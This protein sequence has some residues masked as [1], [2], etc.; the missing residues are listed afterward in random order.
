MVPPRAGVRGSKRV[1]GYGKHNCP[2]EKTRT[3]GCFTIGEAI[4]APA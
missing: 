4:V 1:A 2:M 3:R